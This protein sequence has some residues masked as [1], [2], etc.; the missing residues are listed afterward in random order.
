MTD[1]HERAI[2]A[3]SLQTIYTAPETTLVFSD[4]LGKLDGEKAAIVPTKRKSVWWM[5]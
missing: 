1:F 5:K 4:L 3:D 2:V